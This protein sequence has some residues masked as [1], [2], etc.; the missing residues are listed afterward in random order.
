MRCRQNLVADSPDHNSK[1]CNHTRLA[2]GS[3]GKGELLQF[4]KRS[5]NGGARKKKV[6]DGQEGRAR[7]EA[8]F[9]A[10]VASK[11]KVSS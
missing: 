11:I 8:S 4:Q 2:T 5:M 9:W 6:R 10:L 7:M 3:N 1:M